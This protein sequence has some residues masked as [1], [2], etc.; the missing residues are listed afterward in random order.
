MVALAVMTLVIAVTR[1]A[2]KVTV[3]P[4][5][6]LAFFRWLA[7]QMDVFCDFLD[8][9]LWVGNVR[10]QNGSRLGLLIAVFVEHDFP[11][12]SGF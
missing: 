3:W 10:P 9:Q 8:S 1:E 4:L 7:V 6:I 12:L 5:A 11:F 2:A